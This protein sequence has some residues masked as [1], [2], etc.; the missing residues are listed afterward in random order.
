MAGEHPPIRFRD[1]R[2]LAYLPALDT[3]RQLHEQVLAGSAPPTVLLVEHDPVITIGRRQATSKHLLASPERLRLL[4][5]DIQPSDRGGDITYHGPGQLVAYP[6]I[7]LRLLGVTVS[8]YMRLLEQ[9]VIDTLATFGVGGSRN[10]AGGASGGMTGVWVGSDKICA[11]GVRVRKLVTMHGL[12]LNVDPDLSHFNTIVPC[13][14]A[15]RG[16]TSLRK[17]LGHNAPGMDVV[18]AALKAAFI[19]QVEARTCSPD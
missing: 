18:K 13:G 6:V 2:Q 4:G 10:S 12:A 8:G 1:L 19:R 7:P 9:I 3:Q 5:I 17:L 16:V 11:M 14:L 15:G